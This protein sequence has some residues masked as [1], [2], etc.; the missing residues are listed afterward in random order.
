VISA[1]GQ[2]TITTAPLGSL[3]VTA[4]KASYANAQATVTIPRTG[5]ATANLTLQALGAPSVASG[6]VRLV[7]Q[8]ATQVTIEAD[9]AV[10]DGNGAPIPGLSASAFS[11]PPVTEGGTT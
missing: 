6:F 2:Q 9:V 3:V 8:S 5:Q 1:T 11:V 10:L 4:S 7:D